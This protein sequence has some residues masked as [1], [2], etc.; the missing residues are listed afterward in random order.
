MFH[1]ST[2]SFNLTVLKRLLSLL[3]SLWR[4]H[5]RAALISLWLPPS[6]TIIFGLM[7][8]RENFLAKYM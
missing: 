1:D 5:Y 8:I 4:A 3:I 2:S 6:A 7:L